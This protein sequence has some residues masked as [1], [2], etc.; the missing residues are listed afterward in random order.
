MC[1][2][3]KIRA[4]LV[5][6]TC[7]VFIHWYGKSG[8]MWLQLFIHT[9]LF[10]WRDRLFRFL[11]LFFNLAMS[12]SSGFLVLIVLC[13]LEHLCWNT[14]N[15]MYASPIWEKMCFLK[16]K[17]SSQSQKK[18]KKKTFSYVSP[19]K[20]LLVFI[21]QLKG[22][23]SCRGARHP[24][25]PPARTGSL[26]ATLFPI[27]INASLGTRWVVKM[28]EGSFCQRVRLKKK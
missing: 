22:D 24:V 25:P 16:L 8:I 2:A 23:Y 14:E 13:K 3:I 9:C 5:W 15:Y 11:F 21:Q 20:S 7:A 27:A 10:P 4:C 17:N 1:T 18:K 26:K 28:G 19:W 6:A 12:K